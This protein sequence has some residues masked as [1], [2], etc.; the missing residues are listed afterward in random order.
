MTETQ[1]I[2]NALGGLGL[3]LLGMS[4][5]GD[6]LRELAGSRL[7]RLL[8]RFTTSPLRGVMTGALATSVVQSSSA[9]TVMTVGFV[10]AG[11]LTL[12]QALGIV[13]GANIGTTA[14]GWLLSIFGFG[15]DLRAGAM[16]A[17]LPA[18]LALLLTRGRTARIGRLGAGLA[19]ILIGLGLMQEGAGEAIGR[20]LLQSVDGSGMLALLKLAGIG[21]VATVLIQSSSA[22]I[23]LT[24]VLLQSGTIGL[25]EAAAMVVGMNVGTTFTALM[26]ALGGSRQMKQTAIANLLFNLVT[27]TLALPFVALASG[28]LENL[29]R[30]TGPLTALMAFHTG[31]N[32][33]GTALFL[34]FTTPFCRLVRW[35]VPD[36]RE[37][38]NVSLDRILLQEPEAALLAAHG[39]ATAIRNK[40][41]LAL[42]RALCTPPDLRFLSALV[43]RVPGGLDE[44]EDYITSIP[45]AGSETRQR[46]A[47]SAL[48]HLTDHLRRL[49][50]RSRQSPRIALL[51][52]DPLLARPASALGTILQRIATGRQCETSRLARLETLLHRRVRRYRQTLLRG[53]YPG[54]AG[55]QHIFL[56]TDAMRWL[57]RSLHHARQIMHYGETAQAALREAPGLQKGGIIS[58]KRKK[59]SSPAVRA[60]RQAP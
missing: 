9:I 14:T 4:L 3:F 32:L 12:G 53:A 60:P 5:M 10:G 39:A 41:F 15:F 7:R 37:T 58:P 31:F 28:P 36:D 38:L 46:Q 43:T 21:L 6:A 47:F 51:P 22:T 20:I 56:H 59:D 29:A 33:A 40:I 55:P 11:L 27:G 50:G 48:L 54:H 16:A 18:S 23:A 8:A 13:F 42:S 30:E 19:L 52:T 49:Y 45:V 57:E 26:A 25:P 1:Q 2:L 34:P 17:L 24:L 44:L 35:L